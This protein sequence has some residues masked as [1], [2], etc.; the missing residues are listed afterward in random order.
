MADQL[1]SG[2]AST[3]PLRFDVRDAFVLKPCEVE[4][5]QDSGGDSIV[6]RG[7]FW[8]MAPLA[9]PFGAVLN[10]FLHLA[11]REKADP[12][13]VLRFARRHG[14]LEVCEHVP[15]EDVRSAF[16][17]GRCEKCARRTAQG[18]ELRPEGLFRE[19]VAHWAHCA[20]LMREIALIS[21]KQ[22]S[23]LA[24]GD[25]WLVDVPDGRLSDEVRRIPRDV[26]ASGWMTRTTRF[27]LGDAFLRGD[28]IPVLAQE[29]APLDTPFAAKLSFLSL[30]V[31]G[32]K[33]V[34]AVQLAASLSSG[35]GYPCSICEEP[36]LD[37]AHARRRRLDRKVFCSEECRLEAHRQESRQSY[38][39]KTQ[40]KRMS[41]Y[42]G[43]SAGLDQSI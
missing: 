23:G 16:S 9:P 4:L 12:H 33:A 41:R 25:S 15:S 22:Q 29:R 36:I 6:Y 14:V 18:R 11:R 39:A 24:V 40:P 3:M 19:P 32:L 27:F 5:V 28:I 8:D 1:S 10:D 30:Q 38:A 7:G 13:V 43:V 21:V 20:R 31:Q 17:A 34:L 2:L 26:R 37:E 35:R 42:R